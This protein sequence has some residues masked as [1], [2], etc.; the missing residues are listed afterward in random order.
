MGEINGSRS[1]FYTVLYV[2]AVQQTLLVKEIDMSWEDVIQLEKDTVT[3]G[4]DIRPGVTVGS[5]GCTAL[6]RMAI[7]Y[8]HNATLTPF[9]PMEDTEHGDDTYF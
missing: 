3:R 7:K 1:V 6:L 5:V 2:S 4:P 8:P 9:A